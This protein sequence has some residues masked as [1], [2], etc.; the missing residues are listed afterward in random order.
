M[1]APIAT[2]SS[3]LTGGAADHDDLGDVVHGE[4]R[5]LER[6]LG[7]DD[8]L[9]H[10]VLGEG[11]EL[12]SGQFEVEVLG[13]AVRHGDERQRNLGLG[14]AG[15][16]DFGF[17]RG[18][19]DTLHCHL[20]GGKVDAF[21]GFELGDNPV[22]N[23]LVEIVAAEAVVARGRQHF[24]N[25]VAQFQHGHI[26]CAAAEVEDE[27]F[28]LFVLVLVHAVSQ[29][30]RR[31]FVDDTLDIESGNP[32][33]VLGRLTLRVAEICGHGDDGFGDLL[34]QILFRV[35]LEFG[36]YHRGDFLRGVFL[37]FDF[38]LTVA[39]HFPLYGRNGVFG[40]GNRLSL[41]DVTD[42]SFAVLGKRH[43]GRS[44]T[45]AFGVGDDDGFAAFHNRHA[46][47]GC[48]EVYSYDFSHNRCSLFYK[49]R[50]AFAVV[51]NILP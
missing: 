35:V 42:Q 3:G 28:L 39:A 20:V 37:A 13:R 30:R 8:R 43:D 24:E 15:E 38:D 25:A 4:T 12:G 22:H 41:G 14:D 17:L 44:C 47:V 1:A 31:G 21:G 33:R 45:R 9:S 51:F 27:H 6:L 11:V 49:I 40:V 18:F 50:T 2:H 36:Q 10:E 29:R 34:A 48:S 46:R 23:A 32:A 5:V 19:L 7:R 16:V 26:E